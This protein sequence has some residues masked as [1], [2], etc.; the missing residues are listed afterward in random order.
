MNWHLAY[1]WVLFFG[2]IIPIVWVTQLIR[3][4]HRRGMMSSVPSRL[5]AAGGSMRTHTMWIPTAFVSIA[6]MSL[7]IALS[8]PQEII[9]NIKTTRDAIAIELVVDRSGS[10]EELVTFENQRISRLE[11]VKTVLEKFVVGDGGTLKGREGDLLGL[12]AFG[13]FADTL[14][15]LTQSHDALVEA[16]RRI[17]IPRIERE[18]S[19]AIGDALMLATARLRAS[20]D[21]MRNEMNDPEFTLKSKAIIL[22]TD[23]AN[24]AGNYSPQQAANLAKQW[25]IKVYI[26]G[27]HGETNARGLFFPGS[28]TDEHD[29]KMTKVAQFTGGQFWGV[30]R[31]SDLES[32]YGQIDEL[33][34]ST[35]DVS[36]STSYREWYM[37]FALM[38]VCVYALSVLSRSI[39][40][41]SV[42]E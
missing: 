35:F 6:M 18:R 42:L 34:R 36:E 12:I 19:T 28:N 1:P 31:I 27:V 9:G 14:M 24:Q 10:M 38:G 20:E 37:P 11:A 16:L 2:S 13:S 7:L 23:G 17:E 25:G 41:R 32:V 22:L 33:E 15:P 40:Y 3:F 39:L 21:S 8:R 4:S 30:D 29:Q 26:I 5:A